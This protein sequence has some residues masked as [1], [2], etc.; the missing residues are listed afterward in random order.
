M[1]IISFSISQQ[2]C[3]IV[4][5][6]IHMYVSPAFAFVCVINFAI[7]GLPGACMELA[8]DIVCEDQR[9]KVTNAFPKYNFL[10]CPNH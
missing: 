7:L 5:M 8:Y 4:V 10:V 6:H 2:T 1:T 3:C 9:L